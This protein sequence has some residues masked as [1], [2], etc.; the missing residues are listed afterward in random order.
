MVQ[1]GP[2][3]QNIRLKLEQLV[4]EKSKNLEEANRELQTLNEELDASNEEYQA[5]NEEL[6]AINNE[7][8]RSNKAL[9][10]EI[11]EHKKTQAEK[12]ITEEKLKQFISQS[13][14]AIIIINEKAVVED[15]NETM[16]Q[17]T[18]ITKNVAL[19]KFVWDVT[20]M[21]APDLEKAEF[22]RESFKKNTMLFFEK[23]KHG[24]IKEQVLEARIKH[25]DSSLRYIRTTLFPIV[26]ESGTYGG[27]I[28]S[29]ITQKKE[30]EA[31]LEKYRIELEKL[32]KQRTE[33]LEQLSV[34][35]NEVYANSSDAITFMDI[36]DEGRSIKVFDMNPVS[37]SLFK[38]SDEQL[39][40][41]VYIDELLPQVKIESFKQHFL[42]RLING[43]PVTFTDDRD[44]GNGHWNS[45][46]Y[47][48]KDET[49]KVSRIAAFSR[50]VTAE[51]ERE[52]TSA[53]LNSAIGSWPYEFWVSNKD[54]VCILQNN[55]SQKIWGNLIGKKLTDLD[56]PD[57]IKQ[58]SVAN[59][60]KALSGT[61]VSYELIFKTSERP[62]YVLVNLNPIITKD[63]IT[64]F[65]GIHVDITQQKLAE[66]ALQESEK[67][68]NQLLSAVTNYKF[69]VEFANGKAISTIHSQGCL[70][71]TG[72]SPDD[73]QNNPYL[74]FEMVHDDD[75]QY[76]IEW[77]ENIQKGIE[78]EPVEH[79]IIRKNNE[80]VW[81]SNT[82]VLRKDSEGKL[83]GFDGLIS[84]ITKRKNAELALRESEKRFFDA[85]DL[86]PLP[87]GIIIDGKPFFYNKNFT[88][89][90][91]YTIEDVATVEAWIEK[92]IIDKESREKILDDIKIAIDK[93]NN[94]DITRYSRDYKI[95][96]KNGSEKWI[97]ISDRRIGNMLVTVFNDITERKESEEKI[98]HSEEQYRLL[99]ENIDDVIWKFNIKTLRYT[100]FSPSVIK[101]TG[102]SVE[103]AL[104]L[105]LE[106][107]LMPD[108]Y[109]DISIALPEWI[110]QYKNTH[111]T[112]NRSFAY[113]IRHKNGYA[114][115]VEINAA[116]IL[117]NSGKIQEIVATSRNIDERIAAEKAIRE[118][119]ERFRAIAQ[120]SNNLVYEYYLENNLILWDG[121]IKEVTGFEPEEYK[122]TDF[123]DWVNLIH[124]ED[125]EKTMAL[126]YKSLKEHCPF[127]AQYRYKTKN[128]EYKWIEEDSHFVE[129]IANKPFRML[130]IMRDI[131]EQLRVQTLIQESEKKLKTIFNT[132]KD[133]IVLLNKNMEVF[134]I[135]NSAL[136]R[137]G[138]S[139][140]EILGKNALGLLIKAELSAIAEKAWPNWG[141]DKIDNFETEICI[142]NGGSF[143]VEIS[144][145][146]LQIE[147]QDML[148]LMIRDISERKLLEKQLLHSVINTEERERIHF[149]Q[150]LHDG[151][152]PL[153]SAAKLYTE[154]LAEPEPGVDQKIII[155]DIKKLLEESTLAVKDISFKL[156]PHILQNYG[157]VEALKAYAEKAEKSSKTHIGISAKNV[158]RTSKLTETIIFR[159]LCE[160][161]NNSLKYAKATN[162]NIS[163][164]SAEEFLN[165]DFSDNGIGFD[166]NSITEKHTGIGL[167]NIQ[168]RLKSINGNFSIHSEI[169][170]GTSITIK[171]PLQP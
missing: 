151:L 125:K 162:I 59:E 38:I 16:A 94:Y 27:V 159:V 84:D 49:G 138:F 54:G 91:G 3:A 20:Y 19:G 71:V 119:E 51:H 166:I 121:A 44:T 97:E 80:I 7:L 46:I 92:L 118:S 36:F 128:G 82:I 152:G 111:Q 144:A 102:Y 2:E 28:I 116:L 146:S 145:T 96:C 140:E 73:F 117:D 122:N 105:T 107:I 142:K 52:K 85:L 75:K 106:E 32:L 164:I 124:P 110:N 64:G 127:R 132:S 136:K 21:M 81:V 149:S 10:K 168:S 26:S 148:L 11:E 77:I 65:L 120:L 45:T 157:I 35:F 41:G 153:L 112:A 34:R 100:Y 89:R 155:Q 130:G 135:N 88:E 86:Q 66:L 129:I 17:I 55:A 9:L 103:E 22:Y 133:G 4:E 161:I 39:V 163:L 14:E 30:S 170:G 98:R 50:N 56:I 167:L 25:H 141:K 134:D 83:L 5:I 165:I 23:I 69:T 154:W 62:R 101:L 40:K 1:E 57:A 169:G 109:N 123:N 160:C 150:E 70:A 48:V 12:D 61:A 79:R 60:S 47:P 6:N 67:R 113:Q 78:V 18:G 137:T 63:K 76:L 99:A 139:R 104:G 58:K 42:P 74:W 24:N 114:V 43:E 72:Y 33:H 29:D 31:Q 68:L 15:W 13:S 143:P 147:K 115:W 8:E 108:S 87:I 93:N 131:T 53:I 90:F 156:S 126:Y 37:K 171:V 95:R 158:G